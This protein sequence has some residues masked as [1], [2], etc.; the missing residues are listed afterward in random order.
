AKGT[1]ARDASHPDLGEWRL[2]CAGNPT[3]LFTENETN[4]QRC[5]NTPNASPFVKDGINEY[6]VHNRAEVVNPA[7]VGTKAAAQY[8]LEVAPG[9]TEVVRLRLAPAAGSGAPAA[10]D[11]LVRDFELMFAVRRSE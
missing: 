4:N 6:V 5:F 11:L 1:A 7:Q 8:V 2:H 3:L 9:R 10:K